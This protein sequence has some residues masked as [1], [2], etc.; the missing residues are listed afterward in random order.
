M[1]SHG[2]VQR[3]YTY[4]SRTYTYLVCLPTHI[5]T[6]NTSSSVRSS[7][8]TA[9][10]TEKRVNAMSEC[11]THG[12]AHKTL[13]TTF[14]GFV[15]RARTHNIGNRIHAQTPDQFCPS[16]D[17]PAHKCGSHMQKTAHTCTFTLYKRNVFIHISDEF[18]RRSS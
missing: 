11:G 12:R 5:Y 18:G 14:V 9:R 15:W 3:I 17:R 10:Q 16:V 8:H 4:S 1:C 6:Q 13:T 2:I 7:R